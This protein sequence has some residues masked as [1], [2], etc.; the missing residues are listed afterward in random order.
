[1][2]V[3][4]HLPGTIGGMNASAAQA[5]FNAL[6]T[7]QHARLR[8]FTAD[9][10]QALPAGNLRWYCGTQALGWLPAQRAAW[11]SENLVDCQLSA[12]SLVWHAADWSQQERSD[13]LQT[14]LLLARE[15]GLLRGWRN[16]PFSFWHADCAQPDPQVPA[17]F[18]VERSGYR[19]LGLLSHAVH[20]NGFAPDGRLWCGRRALT[21]AT[22]PGLLDNLAAGGLPSGEA[23]LHCLQRELAE[24][25]GLFSLEG[26]PLQACGSV[27]TTR[28][29]AEGWHDEFIHVYNL[30][31]A[32][33][34]VPQNQDGE[35]AG[36]ECLQAGAV[37]EQIEAG[38]FTVDAV[39]TLILGLRHCT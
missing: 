9:A 36:F 25:A 28:P 29:V 6:N 13:R 4:G 24:E 8:G 1:M 19:F 34:F 31:L 5:F 38:A 33:D 16:E 32:P 30:D 39:Q 15:Q 18:Q 22:D 21:K 17:L 20:V 10:L 27:R 26:L 3:S 11:L 35:V 2:T 14:A 7:G 12:H 37:L 23:V